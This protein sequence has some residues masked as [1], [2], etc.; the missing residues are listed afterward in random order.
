MNVHVWLAPLESFVMRDIDIC[1]FPQHPVRN[2]RFQPTVWNQ[3]NDDSN[4]QGDCTKN[5]R[6]SPL[7]A[8]KPG[9][10]ESNTSNENDHNLATNHD[11]INTNEE[12]VVSDAL[13]DIELIVKATIIVLIEN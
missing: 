1:I 3:T 5:N 2:D 8:I 7:N 11:N 13:K 4:R 10:G 12:P 6:N 9:N